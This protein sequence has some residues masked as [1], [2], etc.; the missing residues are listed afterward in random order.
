MNI[1][2]LFIEA[3]KKDT[4]Y[5]DIFKIVEETVK[6]DDKAITQNYSCNSNKCLIAEF[7]TSLIPL[8][9]FF[10]FKNSGVIISICSKNMQNNFL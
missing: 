5:P 4:N 6:S 10:V 3:L 1:R 9:M 8:S 7:F 2:K